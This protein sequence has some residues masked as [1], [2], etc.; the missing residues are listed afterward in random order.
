MTPSVL[1]TGA[2]FTGAENAR[3]P[4][5]LE[6][7]DL[8]RD[9]TQFSLYIQALQNIFNRPESLVDSYYAVGGIHG[10]PYEEWNDSGDTRPPR[11]TSAMGYCAHRNVLFP[12]WHRPYIFFFEQ[13]IQAEAARIANMY[14]PSLRSRFQNGARV[15]RQPFWDWALNIVPPEEVYLRESLTYLAPNGT[16]ATMPNPFRRYAFK[17]NS[18]RRFPSSPVNQYRTTLRQPTTNS[19]SAVDNT[20]SLRRQANGNAIR[21]RVFNTLK[22]IHSWNQFSNARTQSGPAAD[23]I[24][25][26][27]DDIHVLV[28]GAGH[29]GDIAAAGFDPIFYLHHCNVD[30]LISLWQA[31]NNGVW[32]T[33]GVSQ[34]GTWT[35]PAGSTVGAG[36]DLTPFWRT[37]TTYWTS[38]DVRNT[39]YTAV[40]GYSYPDFNNISM[41][42]SAA[43]TQSAISAR[44]DRLYG[45]GPRSRSVQSR[46]LLNGSNNSISNGSNPDPWVW[47]ARVAFNPQEYGT[48]FEVLV[49]IGEVPLESDDWYGHETY[50]GARYAW[51]N[52]SVQSLVS[53]SRDLS[54][55]IPLNDALLSQGIE[56]LDPDS[57]TSYLDLALSWRIQTASVN[58]FFWT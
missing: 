14:T 42:A 56:S 4:N 41:T 18:Y 7:N 22:N 38:N 15:L 24:E 27:H 21:N 26:L 16:R 9:E 35:I 17:N 55:F 10:F 12:T 57:V 19:S 33:Q 23:S 43:Q 31:L 48:S 49:F 40:S 2:P 46:N 30:R 13:L 34:S 3:R 25:T 50:V 36:S 54:G 51:A 45:Q 29:M 5:R 44:I 37:N 20:S 8:I 6:I 32:V 11:G 52:R 1:I 28:G 39:V 53:P 47:Q 58:L